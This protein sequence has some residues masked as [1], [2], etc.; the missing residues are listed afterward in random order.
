MRFT[1][2]LFS[3]LISYSVYG[4]EISQID[5][6][7]IGK[8]FLS[9][10][11][12]NY[13]T[14]T[15]TDNF[16]GNYKLAYTAEKNG[17]ICYYVFNCDTGGY[18]IVSADNRTVA[19][20]LGYS[21]DGHFDYE[22]L[23]AASK[24]WM[25]SY[26]DQIYSISNSSIHST[27]VNQ[28]GFERSISPLL[29][30]IAWGQ[31]F[32]YNL[33]CPEI[34]GEKYITGCGPTAMAQIMYYHK[35]P[36]R[37]SGI[38]SYISGNQYIEA[39]LNESVYDWQKMLPVY[40]SDASLDSQMAVALLMRDCGYAAEAQYGLSDGTSTV[41]GECHCWVENFNYD[42]G[43]RILP[44]ECFDNDDWDEILW[45]ELDKGRPVLYEGESEVDGE[46]HAFVCDGYDQDGYFHFNFGWNGNINGYYLTTANFYPLGQIMICNI[47]KNHDGNSILDFLSAGNFIYSESSNSFI[48]PAASIHDVVEG[49][50]SGH[51]PFNENVILG[52]AIENIKT[53]IV[54]YFE[55]NSYTLFKRPIV[56][57]YE[58]F[59]PIT[60]IDDGEYKLWP[61]CKR[62]DE[63]RNWI[64]CLFKKS[65]EQQYV[66]LKVEDGKFSFH[67][68]YFE[69]M[70]EGMTY[71]DGIFYSLDKETF[72]AKV[73]VKE[74]MRGFYK[75]RVEIPEKITV[76][77]TTYTINCI[78]ERAFAGCN[79]YLSISIP[80]TIKRIEKEAFR[81]VYLLNDIS[82]PEDSE[83]EYIEAYAFDCIHFWQKIELPNKLK[84]IGEFAFSSIDGIKSLSIPESV[85]HIGNYAFSMLNNIKDIFVYWEEPIELN[86]NV[87]LY[88]ELSGINLNVPKGTIESYRQV[89]P[90]SEFT[91]HDDLVLE[92][93]D[94]AAD[95]E[96]LT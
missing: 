20:V 67:N 37:G 32:P 88:T 70:P 40:D 22:K 75:D 25:D 72:T 45:S 39:D 74:D 47:E 35:W 64:K 31:G 17:K 19:D 60:N 23:N 91:I 6:M 7:S 56:R 21:T 24:Y 33:L 42:K 61:V 86:P 85:T 83:L 76:D 16:Y 13:T 46:G 54:T 52:L 4:Q 9:G 30:N 71:I 18:V 48:L 80:R 89:T 93:E 3:I 84:E 59:N 38:I 82:F 28:K 53:G 65:C 11:K 44:R 1:L 27:G 73:T 26:A 92:I 81:G 79:N 51:L 94:K 57:N 62:A 55:G 49:C 77:N 69:V 5:A 15:K 68:D 63:T 90:W 12:K 41:L 8:D 29:G 95:D 43:I 87:F 78:G 66:S 96:N 14:S 2:L 58:I 34:D 36:V 50:R 10:K